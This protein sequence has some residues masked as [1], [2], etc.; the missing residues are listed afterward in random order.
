MSGFT[1]KD[2]IQNKYLREKFRIVP[3]KRCTDLTYV[4]KDKSRPKKTWL[5]NI[6]NDLFL[7][8]LNENDF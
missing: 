2:R 5:K 1:L 7:L 6:R 3:M 8:N 4:K